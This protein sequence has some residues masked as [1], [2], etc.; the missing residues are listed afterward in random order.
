MIKEVSSRFDDSPVIDKFYCIG[1][2]NQMK[3]I[4]YNCFFV[5][6]KMSYH[7]FNRQESLQK[8]KDG[9]HNGRGKEKAAEYYIENKEVLK[10]NAKNKHRTLSEE[11]IKAKENMEEIDIET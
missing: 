9:Y 4:C 8:A 6:T 10:E 1:V 7:F 3:I 2:M 5:R 11:K